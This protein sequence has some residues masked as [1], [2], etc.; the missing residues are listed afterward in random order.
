MLFVKSYCDVMRHQTNEAKGTIWA[1]IS[2]I[3]EISFSHIFHH[4]L[5]FDIRKQN[6]FL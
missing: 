6:I 2:H 3:N 1:S 4:A 5:G